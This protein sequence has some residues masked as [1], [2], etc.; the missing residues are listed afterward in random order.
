MTKDFKKTFS[1][2]LLFSGAVA[3]AFAVVVLGRLFYIAVGQH[4]YY[5]AQADSQYNVTRTIEPKRG[6]IF[7]S[8]KYST[9]PYP[10]AT[11]TSEGM[12][13]AVPS[14][15]TDATSESTQ[16]AAIIGTSTGLDQPTILQKI[17]A[18]KRAYVSVAHGLT[19]AESTAVTAAKLPGIFLD[20]EDVRYYPEGN[21]MSQV[22]GFVGYGATG[23]QKVGLYGLEKYMQKQLAGSGGQ[24]DGQEDPSGN[25]ISGT[26][27][28]GYTPAVDGSSL[29]L[30]VDRSIQHEVESVLDKAVQQHGADSGTAIVVNP[31]TG[32][33]LA[34]ASYPSFDPNDY[35]KVT[36]LSVF[37]NSAVTEN[38][39]PGSTMKAVTLSAALDQGLITP[40]STFTNTG[41]IVVSGKPIHNS[42]Q[43]DLGT[44][45]MT[46]VID[47]SLNTGAAYVEGL[48]GND[49]FVSYLQKFRFGMATDIELP[50]AEGSLTN[51]KP[52]S[53][54]VNFVTASFGQGITVTPIQVLQAYMAI[55]NGG[56]MMKPYIIDSIIGQDGSKKQTQPTSIGTII[57]QKA[58]QLMTAMLVDDVENGYGKQAAVHGYFIG[59]KTGT[60]QVVAHGKYVVNDNIGS[61]VGYGPVENPQFAMLVNINHPRDVAFAEST[62]APAFGEIAKF[63][64]NYY[65]VPPTRQ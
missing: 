64:L 45:T 17:T 57:S 35:S 62:A 52:G 60:A 7:I 11:T 36:D 24:V 25:L 54:Q 46:Q 47:H 51:L 65:Q 13:Y 1:S 9:T 32:A 58:S 26:S 16:L 14:E 59:G 21:F 56:V 61:F 31:K 41:S 43:T 42:E 39:E 10:V 20:P 12:V 53:A 55:A 18:P 22:L 8:D 38:Y 5:L 28:A 30:T 29:L 23:N 4:G 2:R 49:A 40:T 6:E 44:A 3:V 48:L 37:Q 27:Q 15:V 63:I 33:I 34:M 50:E 19:D